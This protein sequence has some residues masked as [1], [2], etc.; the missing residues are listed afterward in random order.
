MSTATTSPS[1]R[2]ARGPL[3]AAAIALAVALAG[4]LWLYAPRRSESTDNAYLQADSSVV[5]PKVRGLVAEVLVQHDQRVRK[6]DPLIRIDAEEFDARVAAARASVQNA[7]AAIAAARA[8]L[9]THDAELRLAASNV[10]AAQTSIRSSDAQRAL[11]EAD[12]RRYD[13]LVRSGAVARRDVDQYRAAEVTA[14]ANAEHSRAALAASRDQA[15]VTDARGESLRANLAQAEANRATAQAALDLALQDQ[16]NALV[17]APIDGVVGDRQVEAGDYVQPGSRLMTIVPL[18]ALYV[19]ANFK[20]TQTARMMV[21]Q[22]ARV[23]VDAL[24]GETLAARI[25]SFAPGS[26]SQFSLLPFEPGTGNFTKIVQRV[27]VRIRF[28]PG[29]PA[30]ARLRA[31]LSST[32]TVTLDAPANTQASR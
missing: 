25:E 17:R 19:V 29:Q 31:G 4:V 7:D 18:E 1:P 26:G 15:A 12:R 2:R 9:T 13:D 22:R 27:P 21:G 20:E 23:A 32:V 16:R 10:R 28:D 3:L 30:L 6:G 8:A 24:P 5:A 11:A 14:Q